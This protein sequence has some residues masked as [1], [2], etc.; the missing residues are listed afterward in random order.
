MKRFPLNET[1]AIALGLVGAAVIAACSTPADETNTL[2]TASA[3]IATSAPVGGA[4]SAP[5]GGATSSPVG[6]ATSS[7]PAMSSAPVG[8][9]S[10]CMTTTST[11]D[12]PMFPGV[13]GI[14]AY[15]DGVTTIC[16]DTATPG[17]V[18]ANGVVP[19]SDKD[20]DATTTED[21]YA[22]YGAGF[23]LKLAVADADGNLIAPW[24]AAA[25]GIKSLQFDIEGVDG[26]RPIRIQM[27]QVPDPAITMGGNYDE[28][29][30][31]W[32]GNE[33]KDIKKTTPMVLVDLATVTL[34]E[35]TSVLSAADPTMVAE[36]QVIDLAKLDS[37]QFQVTTEPTKTGLYNFCVSNLTWLDMAGMPVTVPPREPPPAGSSTA[38]MGSSTAPA[39]SD[40]APMGSSTAPATSDTAPMGSST[41]P[42]GSSTAPMTSSSAMPDPDALWN[43][44]WTIMAA[45]CAGG[46]CHTANAHNQMWN[47][48]GTQMAS[49][50]AIEAAATAIV[51]SLNLPRN[52]EHAMPPD[53]MGMSGALPAEDIAT[54]EAWADSL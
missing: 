18:C 53:V 35:W 1:H 2:P 7:P 54:I 29:S 30:F 8:P 17:K 24:D 47:V 34:P 3:P 46:T 28:N 41:A 9:M 12:T 49:K 25:L 21:K 16:L 38:P 23:G 26:G 11:G 52:N 37:L 5:V 31:V 48:G 10:N 40:T 27:G 42:M 14:Y 36:G 22:N 4:T 33:K 6:G 39:T 13:L 20:G 32:G 45:S 19:M 43:E 50:A 44:T 15:G 51:T